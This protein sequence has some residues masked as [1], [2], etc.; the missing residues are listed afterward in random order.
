MGQGIT[1]EVGFGWVIVRNSSPVP[2]LEDVIHDDDIHHK[3]SDIMRDEQVE[4]VAESFGYDFSSSAILADGSVTTSYE[5]GTELDQL[6]PDRSMQAVYERELSKALDV[7][8]WDKAL[9]GKPTWLV[10]ITYG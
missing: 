8:G 7:L 3:I 9:L 1:V 4:V 10:L 5:W 2:A 6:A